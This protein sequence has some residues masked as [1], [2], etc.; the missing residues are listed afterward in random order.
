MRDHHQQPAMRTSGTVA[1]AKHQLINPAI[2]WFQSF[3]PSKVRRESIIR[4]QGKPDFFGA[5]VEPLA[6]GSSSVAAAFASASWPVR[7]YPRWCRISSD[8]QWIYSECTA[9]VRMYLCRV[10]CICVSIYMAV[11]GHPGVGSH[12]LLDVTVNS[13][14]GYINAAVLFAFATICATIR[15]MFDVTG[16]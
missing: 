9:N 13:V 10:N 4:H 7:S 11:G 12:Q 16:G 6:P 2:N 15:L 5:P 8:F 14:L 3:W 1:T